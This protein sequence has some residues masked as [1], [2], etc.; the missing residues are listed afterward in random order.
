MPS[1]VSAS[2]E[3]IFMS[4]YLEATASWLKRNLSW[5]NSR[6]SWEE[7]IGFAVILAAGVGLFSIR[8]YLSVSQEV[9]LWALLVS[10]MAVLL[11][12]GWLRLL[13]PMLFYD[14]VRVAR[15]TRYFFFR[16][17]YAL[18][19][20]LLLGWV[21]LVWYLGNNTGRMQPNEMA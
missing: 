4:P 5:S 12:R 1:G 17:L 13:G 20:S 15:R 18:L 3:K 14:L 9:V 6:E 10:A 2:F 21:Y 16:C 7:R 11:R 19:L 8:G